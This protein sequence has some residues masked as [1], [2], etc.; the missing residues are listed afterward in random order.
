MDPGGGYYRPQTPRRG[1]GAAPP[2]DGE[3]SDGGDRVRDWL[4]RSGPTDRLARS[5]MD[6]SARSDPDWDCDGYSNESGGGG[7]TQQWEHAAAGGQRGGGGREE[8]E[9]E[10]VLVREG[11]RGF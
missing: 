5:C 6:R 9:R 7:S 2:S 3:Y 1:R 4:F 10:R 11:E 8:R